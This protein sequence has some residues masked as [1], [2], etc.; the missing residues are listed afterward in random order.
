[1]KVRSNEIIQR[2]QV[3]NILIGGALFVLLAGFFRSQVLM[4]QRYAL[5]SETNRLRELPLPAPR[6]LVV[7][8]SAQFGTPDFDDGAMFA[9]VVPRSRLKA[10]RNALSFAASGGT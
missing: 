8:G 6:G 10:I 3:A 5:Q 4:H 7:T 1:M 9:S 2:A